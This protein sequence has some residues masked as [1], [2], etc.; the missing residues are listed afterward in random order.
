MRYLVHQRDKGI[1][2]LCGLDCDAL[3]EAVD[4]CNKTFKKKLYYG[5][6][7]QLMHDFRFAFGLQ[8]W[9]GDLWDA[10]HV[11]PVVEGGGECGLDN[12]RTLCIPCH[13]KV[14]REL[15]RRRALERR[16]KETRARG[17]AFLFDSLE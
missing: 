17:Q 1:C 2:A 3:W 10:D 9:P 15:A 6:H 7:A 5:E 11:K 16:E 14:T 13:K 12:F 4:W 8:R